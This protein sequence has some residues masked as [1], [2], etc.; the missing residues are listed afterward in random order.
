MTARP[1]ERQPVTDMLREWAR[2]HTEA[3]DQV[4]EIVYGE[5]KRIAVREFRRELREHTLQPTALVHEAYLRLRE[6]HGVVWEDRNRFFGFAAHLM[7]RI[8]VEQARRR[9]TAKR[10]GLGHRVTLAEV[11]QI[12]TSRPPDL[13]ALEEALTT[14]GDLDPRK[15]A[16]VELRFFGGLNIEETAA[17]LGVSQETVGREW[18]RA[19]AWLF[20]ELSGESENA[21]GG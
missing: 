10:G 2:G 12:G 17:V 15:A 18:R 16:V 5:L 9:A 14:L 6:I 7:R 4:V 11:E 21:D 3:G 8:L 20:R 1:A 13:L 19:K